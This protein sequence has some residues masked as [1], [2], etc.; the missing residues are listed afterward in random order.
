[1]TT[2]TLKGEVL[3]PLVCSTA[4]QCSLGYQDA[5][6]ARMSASSCVDMLTQFALFAG[7]IHLHIYA[8]HI[9]L[10]ACRKKLDFSQLWVWKGQYAF[11]PMKLSR[12]A[13]KKYNSP[14]IPKFHRERPLQTGPNASPPNFF[15][16]K[17]QTSLWGV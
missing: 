17:S 13:E 3:P 2:A 10:Q 9:H 1:M 11:N 12:F 7:H 6:T 15:L 16:L 4:P 14:E 5:E 8:G